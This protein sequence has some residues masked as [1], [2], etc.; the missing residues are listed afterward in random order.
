MNH[1]QKNFFSW[2]ELISTQTGLLNNPTSPVHL[3]NLAFVWRYLNFLREKLGKPIFINSAFRSIAVNKA[4]RG[5]ENSYHLQGRA[6]DIRTIPSAM[7]ELKLLLEQQKG[8]TIV[9]LID[10][11]T[12]F[13]IAI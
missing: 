1:V 11:E 13:H 7:P 5:S 10:H 4:V 3:D 6:A 8:K 12:Y 2:S 9:E